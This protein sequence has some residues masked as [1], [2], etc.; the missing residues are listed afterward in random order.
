MIE[1]TRRSP[2]VDL[3]N[4][5]RSPDQFLG[6]PMIANTV[7]VRVDANRMQRTGIPEVVYAGNKSRQD[8][9]QALWHLAEANGRALASRVRPDDVEAIRAALEPSFSVEDHDQARALVVY[10]PGTDRPT[11]GGIV[12]VMSAG[13]SDI[14]VAAEAALMAREMGTTVLEAWD[15]G[16]AGLH[17]LVEPLERFA[18]EPIDVLIIAAGM[19]GALPSV[20]AG[21][22][23][24]PV[25]GLP[26]SI[27]YGLG[28]GGIGALTA[29]LQSCAPGLVVVNIDNGIGA[30]STAAL[31][32]NRVAASRVDRRA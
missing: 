20:V 19:D 22:V 30:G 6:E 24:V 31:I 1:P 11:R 29:M 14:P 8:V 18:A 4:A 26:T 5:L 3:R 27:G 9:A 21:L 16:V 17:R 12:G 10:R 7:S 28:A 32:A 2:F 25:I 23:D 13:T 15:V